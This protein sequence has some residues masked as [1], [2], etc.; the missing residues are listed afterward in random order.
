[1]VFVSKIVSKSDLQ[2]IFDKIS[3]IISLRHGITGCA[4]ITLVA[5]TPDNQIPHKTRM[6]TE[7]C[8]SRKSVIR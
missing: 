3:K 6:L 5:Y 8:A 4:R 2:K 1:M 7:K